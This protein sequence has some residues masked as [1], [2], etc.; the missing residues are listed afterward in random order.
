[1]QID[2]KKQEVPITIT[3][4]F[5]SGGISNGDVSIFDNE[6][7]DNTKLLGVTPSYDTSMGKVS[8]KVTRK[9]DTQPGTVTLW[10]KVTGKDSSNKKYE[11][12]EEITI[13]V[14]P[15][16]SKH[17]TYTVTGNDVNIGGNNVNVA[18]TFITAG[19]SN[20]NLKLNNA[21]PYLDTSNNTNPVVDS[22]HPFAPTVSGNTVSFSTHKNLDPAD[23]TFW[24]EV[25][26][27]SDTEMDTNVTNKATDKRL[28]YDKFE[29][30]FVPI[31]PVPP[32]A[33]FTFS[34]TTGTSP[35]AVQYTDTSTGGPTEWQWDFNDGTNSTDKNPLHMFQNTGPTTK[36]YT[37]I[38]IVTNSK[39]SSTATGSV[40]VKPKAPVASFTATP[41]KGGSPLTVQFTDTSIGGVPST[42]SWDFGDGTTGTGP[43][44]I[45]Q[46]STTVTNKKYDVKLTV[47]NDGGSD[48]KTEKNFIWVN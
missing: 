18:V 24:V 37:V 20:T 15:M 8:F 13:Y 45:H 41:V 12:I 21:F 22:T 39:G 14:Q 31:L 2:P 29:K 27:V 33:K 28:Y 9:V 17:I 4:D 23:V 47:T 36:T 48:T 38:L 34:P 46:Y 19:F 30:I 6:S 10:C 44:P 32:S 16:S 25:T 26:G 40:T 43:N 7:Y 35:L 11:K 3:F 5:A 1:V 42:W